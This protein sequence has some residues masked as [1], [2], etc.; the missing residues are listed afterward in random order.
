M[1]QIISRTPRI[2][3]WWTCCIEC[4]SPTETTVTRQIALPHCSLKYS[5][6]TLL[7]IQ[8]TNYSF[9]RNSY[10]LLYLNTQYFS[11]KRNR[12]FQIKNTVK[13]ILNASEYFWSQGNVAYHYFQKF[14][15]RHGYG[16]N[17]TVE[18]QTQYP[19]FAQ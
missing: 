18:L 15:N 2:F 4:Y 16:D 6:M 13:H 10:G 9:I 5:F 17:L 3:I 1:L 12:K 19:G 7:F 8:A 11:F 14:C